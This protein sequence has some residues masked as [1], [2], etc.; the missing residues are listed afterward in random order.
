MAEGGLYREMY[1]AQRGQERDQPE[2]SEARE[3]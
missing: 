3:S 2:V 1:E